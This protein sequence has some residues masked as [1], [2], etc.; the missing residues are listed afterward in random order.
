M[1]P[2]AVMAR[3]RESSALWRLLLSLLIGTLVAVGLWAGW[4]VE[5]RLSVWFTTAAVFV[6]LT[7]IALGPMD[8]AT[9]EH[10]ARR[11]DMTTGWSV[12]LVAAATL[13]SLTSV[14]VALFR[15]GNPWL[16][17]A[18]IMAV[19]TS[20][21]AIHTLFATHYARLYY[22]DPVGGIDFN[23]QELPR[24]VDFA[25]VSF[26][27]GMSFT[28]SDTNLSG[29]LMRRP[30]LFQALLSYLF[31]TVILALVINLISGLSP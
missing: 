1:T 30:A 13:F 25:Y 14:V 28:V 31:G 20:W 27:I 24:F 5:V 26:T 23:Q 29:S 16:V 8:A 7:W 3:V 18:T 10:F 22:T 4:R 2:A 19:V 12:L 21:T 15:H 11:G 17:L 6:V 9:T